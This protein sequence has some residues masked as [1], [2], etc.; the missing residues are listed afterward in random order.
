MPTATLPG[1]ACAACRTRPGSVRATVPRMTRD[2]P[3]ASHISIPAIS[4]I[5]PPSWTGIVTAARIASTLDRL[6]ARPS[7]APLRSTT[8]SHRKPWA[9]NCAAWS[10][11]SSLNT[12]SRSKSPLRRRTQRP[13]LRSIAGYRIM[14]SRPVH[15]RRAA[16]PSSNRGRRPACRRPGRRKDCGPSAH[17][18]ALR[19]NGSPVAGFPGHPG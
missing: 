2:R 13:S 7:T 4:R 14:A 19:I 16:D 8:C 11:G 3:R 9:W 5:P 10:A 1:K 17:S 15:P 18:S 6:T 12:V